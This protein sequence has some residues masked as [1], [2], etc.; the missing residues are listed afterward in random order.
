MAVFNKI[1][2]INE[3]GKLREVLIGDPTRAFVPDHRDISVRSFDR[4]NAEALK[5]Q[6]QQIMPAK[7]IDETLED[8]LE[9]KIALERRGVV[10]HQASPRDF[11]STIKSPD[12]DV[13]QESG[14]NIRDLTFIH[15]NLIIDAPSPTRNR[16]FESLNVRHLFNQY[17]QIDPASWY[18]SPPKPQL[19]DESYNFKKSFGLNEIEPLFD[20]ANC[21]RM[22]D[23]V[24]IDIN[25]TANELGARWLQHTLDK[26]YGGRRVTVHNL[27]CS[28]DHID[29]ILIPLREGT[30][31]INPEYLSKDKIPDAFKN[32]DVIVAPLMEDQPYF[33]GS[34]KASNWIGLNVLVLDGERRE[35]I[36]EKSQLGLI[37]L[38]EANGFDVYPI[39]WR[40]GRTWGGAFH[41]VTLDLHREGDL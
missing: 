31:L 35:V 33:I 2:S 1:W 12:W 7:V 32:W 26:H 18:V 37:R 21:I 40:H 36:A 28:P 19:P 38:L 22:G 17:T 6:C 9:L 14:I 27:Q 24:I 20:A 29:V 13:Y 41:C 30:F 23:D 11:T 10:V 34:P 8:I 39:T 16:I 25:N 15:G 4:P 3:W 5:L